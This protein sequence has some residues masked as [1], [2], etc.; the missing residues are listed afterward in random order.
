MQWTN[1]ACV[2]LIV[3]MDLVVGEPDPVTG[4]QPLF[5]GFLPIFN[6]AYE[7]FNSGWYE[8]V[9]KTICL[10][11]CINIVSPHISKLTIPLITL[12]FRFIDRG[13]SSGILSD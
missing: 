10:T 8:N 9:G 13:C 12:L 1:I 4:D 7:D 3:N 2:I 6:G 5:L 11:M